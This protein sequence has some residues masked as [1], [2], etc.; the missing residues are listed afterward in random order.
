VFCFEYVAVLMPL[1]LFFHEPCF[2]HT[3]EIN[4]TNITVYRVQDGHSPHMVTAG[5]LI[6]SVTLFL[7]HFFLL[8]FT[9]PYSLV[10]L[11]FL[12]SEKLIVNNF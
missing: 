3:C 7:I 5:H 1:V 12:A 11:L 10:P 6:F 4:S 2:V 9:H 8:L